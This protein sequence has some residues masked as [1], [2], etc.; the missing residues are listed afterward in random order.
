MASPHGSRSRLRAI[1]GGERAVRACSLFDPM[2]ARI[3]DDLGIEVGLMGGS[4]AALAVLGAPDLMLLTLTELAEQARRVSR[5]GKLCVLV[6]AD[7]GYG[8]ALNVMRTVAELDAAGVAGLSIEDTLLPRA[9]GAGDKTQL[10]SLEE[11]AGKMKA[12]VRAR[13]ASG[14]AIFARTSA[15]SVSGTEDA[16][17]RFQAYE[18]AGVDALFIPGVK[19]REDLDA[20]AAAVKLP[21]ITAGVGEK[22][23]D[24]EYLAGRRV[25]VFATGHEPFAAAVQA[26]YDTMKAIRDGMPG[27]DLA[28]IAPREL[29]ARLTQ[30]ADYEAL[31]REY[32]H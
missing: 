28:G 16:V 10:L 17:R 3:A 18:A 6:D 13:G 11:G 31:T 9:F 21:I 20:I 25:R 15:H 1:L 12:A 7:H 24:A 2:S 27:K 32:L 8:N 22:V 19:K 23:A 29:M 30:G 4:V 5:A 14:M 26:M